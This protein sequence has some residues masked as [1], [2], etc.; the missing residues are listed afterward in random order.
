MELQSLE[1]KQ[2]EKVKS[3]DPE[4]KMV[5]KTDQT[6]AETQGEH[7]GAHQGQPQGQ[8]QG[9]VKMSGRDVSVFYGAKQ[10]LYDVNLD[11]NANP[12]PV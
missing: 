5:E 6:Q 8:L 11:I 10:A 7:Q 12:F 3:K 9:P 4:E 2:A 1:P